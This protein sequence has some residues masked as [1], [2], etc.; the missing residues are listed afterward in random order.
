MGDFASDLFCECP[1]AMWFDLDMRDAL[2]ASLSDG[3]T[4]IYHGA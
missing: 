1:N 3:A 4:A 2:S